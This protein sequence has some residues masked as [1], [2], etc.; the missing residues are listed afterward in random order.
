MPHRK[1]D[2]VEMTIPKCLQECVSNGFAIAGLQFAKECFCG[3]NREHERY[4][5]RPDSE[6]NMTCTGDMATA[7]GGF[8]R[9]SVYT[10]PPGKALLTKILTYS[11]LAKIYLAC[12]QTKRKNSKLLK[13]LSF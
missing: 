4:G 10:V 11:K 6:C 2:S 3:R 9:L 5:K 12:R 8:F 7:C 1:E 13:N